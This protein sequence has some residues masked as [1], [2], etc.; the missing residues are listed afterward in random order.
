MGE[1]HKVLGVIGGLGPM[2]TAYFLQLVT[3]MSDAATDQEHIEV[4][5][6]SKPQIPDR[7]RFILGKSSESPLPEMLKIGAQLA[8]LGAQVLAIPCITA[9]FFQG[10]LE[11]E[12]GVPVINAIEETAEYLRQEG[13][14]RA[15]LLA[16]DGTVQSRLFQDTFS[17]Y[18]IEVITPDEE[19]QAKVMHL[20]Y[21]NVKA[22]VR[23]ETVLLE[24]VGR[25]LSDCGAQVLLLA[26]T[27]L[28]IIKRDFVLGA[29]YL[30]VL[31]VLARKAVMECGRLKAG[32]ERL[33]A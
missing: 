7:T 6:H 22:G 24:Q 9:H 31:E 12:I 16:T 25:Q 5:I 17:S 14:V 3:Q 21:Q 20:I 11:R 4:L 28:S 2:A 1:N 30:D 13:I 27:E 33:L 19:H 23:P 15:G 10:R 8:G 26:C 18:G 29:E 32:Y